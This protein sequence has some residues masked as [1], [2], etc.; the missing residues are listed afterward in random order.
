VGDERESCRRPVGPV[1]HLQ[2]VETRYSWGTRRERERQGSIRE[3]ERESGENAVCSFPSLSPFSAFEETLSH[4]FLSSSLTQMYLS[5]IRKK[6]SEKG[7]K[8]ERSEN[9]WF[10]HFPSAV[11]SAHRQ[12]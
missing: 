7:K 8:R 2:R 5:H 6:E 11:S 4:T 3:R 12:R 10:L 1:G 9:A